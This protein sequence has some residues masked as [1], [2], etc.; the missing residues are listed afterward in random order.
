MA[1]RAWAAILL[2]ALLGGCTGSG[3]S[4]GPPPADGPGTETK[5]K[6]TG[7]AAFWPADAG[8]V[9]VVA[10][11]EALAMT[12]GLTTVK[13]LEAPS[14]VANWV[15]GSG[16]LLA[17]DLGDEL[18][19]VDLATGAMSRRSCLACVGVAVL[20]DSIVSVD[21]SF[22]M[23]EF[24]DDLVLR[25]TTPVPHVTEPRKPDTEEFA[26][27]PTVIGAL[28]GRVAMTYLATNAIVR[29]GP[30]ILSL[31][32]LDGTLARSWTVDGLISS[33]QPD[34]DGTRL[35]LGVGGSGGACNTLSAPVIVDAAAGAPADMLDDE[36]KR[37][38]F[39]DLRATD[40]WWNGSEIVAVGL[41]SGMSDN[42]DCGLDH[43]L[44]RISVDGEAE[45][46]E[47]DAIE[48]YRIIGSGCDRALIVD[49][50]DDPRLDAVVDGRRRPMGDYT[51][52]VWS[53]PR[54]D[55]CTTLPGIDG[56]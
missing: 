39:M 53:A 32:E 49:S 38:D 50:Q 45:E 37:R 31:Y 41:L 2:G 33:V 18:V 3:G 44:W 56:S 26:P 17:L 6:T 7:T 46:A 23:L 9:A 47:I 24:D 15:H 21:S 30:E 4:G 22:T 16:D 11:D 29:G 14:P 10:N 35:V 20:G 27:T 1:R 25:R 19:V 36:D 43:V 51:S 28:D 55:S 5:T 40:L 42:G 34:T 12:D 54:S 48:S 13:L 52:I 8:D